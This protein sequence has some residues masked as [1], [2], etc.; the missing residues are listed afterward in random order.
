MKF[1]KRTYRRAIRKH[2]EAAYHYQQLIT[3]LQREAERARWF[4]GAF[5]RHFVPEAPPFKH[6]APP[7]HTPSEPPL[8]AYAHLIAEAERKMHHSTRRAILIYERRK[9]EGE[10]PQ[11]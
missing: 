9:R 2:L 11:N 1:T 3:Q 7:A 5:R 8:P 4:F 6:P 10:N